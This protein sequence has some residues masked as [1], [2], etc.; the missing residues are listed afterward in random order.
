MHMLFLLIFLIFLIFIQHTPVG[1]YLG[2]NLM[3][4]DQL[5]ELLK[6]LSLEQLRHIIAPHLR[7]GTVFNF[8]ITFFNLVSQEEISDVKCTGALARAALSIVVQQ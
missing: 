8:Q 1:Q 5:L 7:G 2:R 3:S 6:Q 4:H